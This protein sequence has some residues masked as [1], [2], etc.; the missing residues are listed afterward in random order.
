M[1]LTLLNNTVDL[2]SLPAKYDLREL[3]LVTPV[4]KQGSMG[5]CWAFGMTAA[6]ESALLKA[7]NYSADFSENNMRNSMIRYSKYG[8]SDVVEGGYNKNSM[9][10]LLSWF[11]AFPRDYDDYDEL[12]KISPMIM[13][14]EDVHI[15]D[16]VIIP[17][18]P[19]NNDSINNVKR[20]I[21][22]Y[23][24]LDGSLCSN[25]MSDDKNPI[26]YYNENTSAQYVPKKVGA[27]HEICIVGWDDNYSKN[28]FAVTPPG[29]GAWIVKNS[30]GTEWGDKGYFYVSFYDKSLCASPND[31]A[32]CFVGIVIENNL[33]YN[34]NYQYDFSGLSN[35]SAN[36][37]SVT[38]M[39]N[40]EAYEDDVIAAVG[41]YF[42]GEGVDYAIEI[43]VNGKLAY[44]QSGVSPYYG[45][46][47]IKLDKYVS[48]KKGDNFSVAINSNAL[49][50]STKSRV[51]FENG[52]SLLYEDGIWKDLTLE[53][54]VACI[55]AYTLPLSDLT[56]KAKDVS[57][58]YGNN[59]KVTVNVACS[60]VP[61]VGVT[62]KV[63]FNGKTYSGIS[64]ET[65]KV[66]LSIPC[67]VDAKK[68]NSTVSVGAE[69]ATF[70]IT[71]KKAT[72][73]ITAK[74]KTFK[75]KTKTKKYA[76]TLKDNKGKAI[77]KVKLTLKVKGKTYTA[78][79]SSKGKATFKI[80]K[81]SKKGTF[82]AK[83]T[84]AGNKCFN[85]VTKTVKIKIKK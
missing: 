73:K 66:T 9:A 59:A 65:G 46:H 15:Y 67:K 71:V 35:F 37:S 53:G 62:V 30:W 42:N 40:Y 4:K 43:T 85:K 19:G 28:N 20:A 64:D 61:L 8:V 76:V 84:Y 12:G 54:K 14:E 7:M 13:T 44:T 11:G 49:P 48:I 56:L 50:F 83:I 74:A 60:N 58:V 68:Y 31:T 57:V 22:K 78:K 47:T 33:S 17:H 39:N 77:K 3:S 38:Y 6:L 70:K 75:V 21:L 10:Y 32:D 82:K 45:Y 36:K 63:K 81:L 52:S 72:P 41:T 79:T 69:S 23:G 25:S 24:A 80:T 16:I 18:I 2:S 1:Q 34:N 26:I 51:H 55:K 5:A 29:D 27:N